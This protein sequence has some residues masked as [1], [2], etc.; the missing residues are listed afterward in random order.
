MAETRARDTAEAVA[1]IAT[2]LNRTGRNRVIN[3]SMAI[4]QRGTSFTNPGGTYT[5]DRFGALGLA[6][7]PQTVTRQAS[8]LAGFQYFLRSQRP[9]AG[10]NTNPLFIGYAFETA[11]VIP[12][13]GQTATFSFYARKGA[14]YSATDSA[15]G[16]QLYFGTGT[17]Q[18]PFTSHTG[19]TT[20]VNTAATLT[21]SW[22]RFTYTGS[23]PS[24]ATSS[25]INWVVAPTGTAGAADYFD[26]TGV[27]FEVSP[28]ATTFEIEDIGMTLRKCQRYYVAVVTDVAFY[29]TGSSYSWSTVNLPVEQR[30]FRLFR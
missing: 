8:D 25:R 16:A 22:Q 30:T 5:A 27:Q 11:D 29:A 13:Q 20:F 14:N 7:S 24:N 17:D 6:G 15:L 21:T 28:S 9:A 18:G 2:V 12:T 23:I 4:W 3:G 10:T 1:S 26:I 19:E